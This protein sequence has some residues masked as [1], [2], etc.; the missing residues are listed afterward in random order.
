MPFI[1]YGRKVQQ[2]SPSSSLTPTH[3]YNPNDTSSYSGGSTITNI[4]SVGNVSGTTGTLSGVTYVQNSGLDFDGGS[5][6]VIF[7]SYDFGNVMTVSAWVYPRAEFSINTV[8]ANAYAGLNANGFKLEWN[9]WQ[10]SDLKMLIEAGNGSQGNVLQSVD[11]VVVLEE[12]QQLIWVI[13]FDNTTAQFYR[14]GVSVPTTGSIVPNI[15]TNNIWNIGSMLSSYYMNAT[16]GQLKVFDFL[17]DA[18]DAQTE[19]N[20]TKSLFG[21]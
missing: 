20:E 5:D 9:N 13:D 10:T 18:N 4:G 1:H 6:R 21:L 12:W 11:P 3:F 16:L 17:L 2:P 19:F 7:S 8:M 14:N 15:N